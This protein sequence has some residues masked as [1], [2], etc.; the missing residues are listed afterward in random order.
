MIVNGNVTVQGTNS[1][2]G[3]AGYGDVPGQDALLVN[4]NLNILMGSS[5]MAQWK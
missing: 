5:L 1:I 2:V 3:E 4:G